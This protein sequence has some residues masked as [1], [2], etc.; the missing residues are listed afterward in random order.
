MNLAPKVDFGARMLRGRI[1]H[2][3]QLLNG[4]GTT[5]PFEVGNF[6]RS[7]NCPFPP[8][9]SDYKILFCCR[10]RIV[11][12]ICSKRAVEARGMRRA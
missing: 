6:D 7:L 1:F 8:N 3:H 10:A 11:F 9:Y 4:C 2:C 12:D 5:R